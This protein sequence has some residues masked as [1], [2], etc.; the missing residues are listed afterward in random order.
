V[1]RA[2][3]DAR[4]RLR[5]ALG[6]GAPPERIAAAWALGVGIGLSP[7]IGLHTALALLLAVLLRLNKID[8]LLG[9]MISNPWVLAFY[10]P[11][12]VFLGESLLG[13]SVPRVVIP[14]LHQLLSAAAWREQEEWLRPLLLAWSAGSGL[15]AVAGSTLTFVAV[16]GGIT[17]RRRRTA[18]LSRRSA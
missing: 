10:F 5:L 14:E 18:G 3:A 6:A 15:V 7:L 8:V 9:T 12:C 2:L 1:R 13:I 11:A 4:D 17:R 16:R